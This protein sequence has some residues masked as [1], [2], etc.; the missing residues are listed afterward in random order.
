MRHMRSPIRI[1]HHFQIAMIG[2]DKHHVII[3]KRGVHNS[4]P[5]VYPQQTRT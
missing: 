5:D 1:G 4:D 3:G 2:S